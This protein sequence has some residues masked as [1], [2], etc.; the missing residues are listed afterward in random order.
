[1]NQN[2]YVRA[3][4]LALIV[5]AGMFAGGALAASDGSVE[6]DPSTADE[7]AQHVVTVTVGD[8]S[9][10]SLTGLEVDYSGSG[11]DLNNVSQADIVK[12]G[13]D[14]D[15][16]A[17]GRETDENANDD[18][19]SVS[20]SNDGETLRI[21]TG[22]SYSIASGDEIV[23]VVDGVTNPAAGEY[24]VTLDVNP[25]SSGGETTATL[26]IG[27]SGGDDGTATDTDESDAGDGDDAGSDDA[28]DGDA[29]GETTTETSGFGVVVALVALT[30]TALLVARRA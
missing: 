1:M 25:Q 27:D 14:R 3:S 15:D 7:T 13:I 30:G 8:D 17:D 11:I 4:L 26:S 5:V 19:D 20:A 2:S 21:D 29:D 24:D 18:L 9:A 6:A 23:V 10:G 28:G 22:G 16:D 12:I